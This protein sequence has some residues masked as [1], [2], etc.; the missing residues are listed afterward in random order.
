MFPKFASRHLR[1]AFAWLLFGTLLWGQPYLATA[2]RAISLR[3]SPSTEAA[4][5]MILKANADLYVIDRASEENGFLE[6]TDIKTDTTGW[7][8][9]SAILFKSKIKTQGQSPFT[10]R[11]LGNQDPPLIEVENKSSIRITLVVGGSPMEILPQSKTEF[12]LEPG[13][14]SYRASAPGVIPS[15]GNHNF[16]RGHKYTWSFWIETRRR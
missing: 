4:K 7:V 9:V 13:G 1:C 16:Q 8:P 15:A 11:N 2:K 12:R 6:V 5:L 10:G 3:E 14:Y